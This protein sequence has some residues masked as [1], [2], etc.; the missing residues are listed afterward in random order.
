MLGTAPSLARISCRA[1]IEQHTRCVMHQIDKPNH[2]VPRRCRKVDI[3]SMDS[4]SSL[5]IVRCDIRSLVHV[6][7]KVTFSCFWAMGKTID[8]SDLVFE[9]FPKPS[10]SIAFEK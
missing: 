7:T 5:E 3:V 9:G 10:V 8:L 6:G 4:K 2:L 1:H